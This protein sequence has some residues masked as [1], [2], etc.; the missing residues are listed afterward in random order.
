MAKPIAVQITSRIHV[1]RGRK[2]VRPRQTSTPAVQVIGA[3]GTRN[4]RAVSGMLLRD[5]ENFA[6]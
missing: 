1:S 5:R 4:G 3:A 2:K 6:L